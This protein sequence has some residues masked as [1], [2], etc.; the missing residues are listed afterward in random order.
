MITAII[1]GEQDPMI[2][3]NL[4]KG[5]L[6]IK[7]QELILALEGH[8][9]EH[10]RFMLSLSKTVI[11]QLNDLLG[12]VDNRIDQYLKKWEEEVKLLQTIPGVQ[13]QTAT[14]ILAEIGTDMHAFLISIIWLV[15]VVYVLVI[16]KVPEKEK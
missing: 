4:A 9:N 12:Q 6:K 14:A 3:A 5:R 15:G 2:L 8:L 7:K 16:M 13:K 10:H 11:L 1:E